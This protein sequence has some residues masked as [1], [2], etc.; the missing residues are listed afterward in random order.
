[1]DSMRIVLFTEAYLP[2]VGGVISHVSFLAEQL[3]SLGHEVLIAASDLTARDFHLDHGVLRCPAKSARNAY[4]FSIAN[5]GSNEFSRILERFKPDLL[6]VHT[7]SPIGQAAVK[8]ANRYDLPLVFTIHEYFESQLHYLCSRIGEPFTKIKYRGLFR[9]MVDNADIVTAPSKKAEEYLH[10]SKSK[11]PLTIIP[12]QVDSYFFH[13]QNIPESKIQ[14]LRRNLNLPPDSTVAIYAGRLTIDKSV[15]LLL[16]QWAAQIKPSDNLHLLV[17]GDGPEAEPLSVWAHDLKIGSQVSF[18]GAVPHEKM[19]EYYAVSDVFV[20]AAHHDLMSM[21][22]LEAV[23]CGLPTLLPHDKWDSS[24]VR[25]GVS[26]FS[27]RSAREF[28]EYLKK[29][30]SLSPHRKQIL[31]RVVRSSI[32]DIPQHAFATQILDVYNEAVRLHSYDGDKEE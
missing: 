30:A 12:N 16:E 31:K 11:V 3:S 2:H 18:V 1:M 24:Q 13:Y 17:V 22:A 8:F 6:H 32:Q 14:H 26:G 15:E 29:F 7:A 10:A 21:A 23:A 5:P 4:G 27:Y 9:D 28:G 20:T 25:E 19:P